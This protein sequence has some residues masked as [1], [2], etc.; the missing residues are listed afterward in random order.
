MTCRSTESTEEDLPLFKSCHAL[1]DDATPAKKRLP[2][3]C[4]GLSYEYLT[5]MMEKAWGD[6][7]L[8]YFFDNDEEEFNRC[9]TFI[10]SLHV[11]TKKKKTT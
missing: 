3:S 11:D 6:A 5:K 1:F 2:K 10:K 9:K 8:A 4:A 7:E